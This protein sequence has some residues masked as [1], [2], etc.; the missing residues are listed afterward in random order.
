MNDVTTP[1]NLN[2]FFGSNFDISHLIQ[3]SHAE[4]YKKSD[5]LY[6]IINSILERN[7]SEEP[8]FIVDLGKII[9]QFLKWEE[10]LPNVK[11]YY[12]IKSN[13]NP[14]IIKTLAAL[15]CNFDCASKN[16]IASVIS[17]TS[18]PSRI[19]F[20]NPCKMSNQIQYARTNDVDLMTFDSEH[21]LYKIKLYHSCSDLILRI[22]VDD[23]KSVCKFSSKFGATLEE[24]KTLFAIA[25][26]L[27]LN[28]VGISFHVGSGC[29]D[30][31]QYR[32]AIQ[33]A[34]AFFRLAKDEF[35]MELTVL[36]IGGG[37][38]GDEAPLKFEDIA[39]VVNETIK[40]EFEGL[41]MRLIAEPGR[42]LVA[43]SHT[44]MINV[45]GKK[46]RINEKGE[47]E[48]VLYTNDGQYSSFNCIYFD[49]VKP[50]LIPFNE[51]DGKTFKATVFG[52]TCDSMDIITESIALPNLA[53]GEWLYCESFGAYTSAAATSF[54][55]FGNSKII[56]ILTC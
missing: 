1:S 28:V 56:Y 45:I 5:E 30:L 53:I 27:K 14:L 51:R 23:C 18:D 42:F 29:Q 49:H 33:D 4:I 50:I 12:A 15:G 3:E 32:M 26:T 11:P 24:A 54:N 16:E 22:K 20:A 46:E 8:F 19:I 36:D 47:T 10:L 38:P 44:L 7:M 35:Q 37:F 34:R 43:N 17:I 25:K 31:E 52:P 55:G 13:P 39:R 6:D 9:R 41:E 2:D 40:S 21:E 48:L